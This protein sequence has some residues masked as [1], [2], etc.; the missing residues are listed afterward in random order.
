MIASI[1][2][3]LK[4]ADKLYGD[5]H[6]E[7]MLTDAEWVE[8]EHEARQQILRMQVNGTTQDGLLHPTIAGVLRPFMLNAEAHGRAVARTVRP[9]V[10]S[11]S[12]GTE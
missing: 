9:L 4:E 10:G 2:K 11:S 5:D 7:S 12:E 3:S 1:L 8:L 6:G